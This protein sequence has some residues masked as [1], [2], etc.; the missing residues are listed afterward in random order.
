[1]LVW[2]TAFGSFVTSPCSTAVVPA[3]YDAMRIGKD[4]KIKSG[5]I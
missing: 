3:H 2:K 4:W 5:G 1:M